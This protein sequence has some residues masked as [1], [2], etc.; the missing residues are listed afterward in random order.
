MGLAVTAISGRPI[1]SKGGGAHLIQGTV[2][3][4]LCL[5]EGA[6]APN[7]DVRED[8]SAGKQN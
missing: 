7:V 2:F 4:D 1:Q 8:A 6:R 3:Q 5:G